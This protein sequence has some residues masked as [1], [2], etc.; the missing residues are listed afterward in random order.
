MLRR[1]RE[2]I[3]EPVIVDRGV[4]VMAFT[5][6]VIYGAWGAVSTL[7]HMPT[8]TDAAPPLYSILWGALIG[9][10][11]LVAAVACVLTF[12]TATPAGRLW[13]KRAEMTAVC[14]MGGLIAVYPALL[15]VRAIVDHDADRAAIAVLG[16]S[17]L[18]VPTWRIR[19]LTKRIRALL[20]VE[21]NG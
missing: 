18:V 4:D 16:L 7:A 3:L 20:G 21:A 17:Y 11:A 10:F 15:F 1:L 6:W 19:H 8:L 13:K 2:R 5:L 14:L 9:F 12:F